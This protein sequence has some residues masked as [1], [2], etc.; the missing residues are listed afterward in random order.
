MDKKSN[1]QS[2][3]Y[4]ERL[5]IQSAVDKVKDHFAL[6]HLAVQRYRDLKSNDNHTLTRYAEKDTSYVLREI[7]AGT[8]SFKNDGSHNEDV[9]KTTLKRW[10]EDEK[11]KNERRKSGIA[12]EES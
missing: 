8:C 10:I 4:S 7:Q 3:G 1:V 6:I 11:R 5:N 2:V 12:S 9:V